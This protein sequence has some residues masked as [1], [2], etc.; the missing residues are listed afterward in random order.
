MALRV[1]ICFLASLN[2]VIAAVSSL[3]I[4]RRLCIFKPLEQRKTYSFGKD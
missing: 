2:R 3:F 4:E 1:A